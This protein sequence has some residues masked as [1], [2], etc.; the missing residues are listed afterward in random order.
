MLL[1]F[2]SG[3]LGARAFSIHSFPIWSRHSLKGL[4]FL[5]GM[6]WM[7]R[8]SCRDILLIEFCTKT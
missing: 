2:C 6:D 1:D 4:A 5:E 3:N 8:R 7:V